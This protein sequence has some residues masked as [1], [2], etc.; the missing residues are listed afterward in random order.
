[1]RRFKG[2]TLTELMIALAVLGILIAVVTPAI[3]KARPNKN[4]M[5]TKKVYYTAENAVSALI[6]D[7]TVYPDV[8][9]LCVQDTSGN[10]PADC[11]WGFDYTN[12][13]KSE[14]ETYGNDTASDT[15]AKQKFGLLFKSKLNVKSNVGVDPLK[16]KTNDGIYWDLTGTTGA[17][18]KGKK[19]VGNFDQCKTTDSDSAGCGKILVNVEGKSSGGTVCSADSAD[20]NQFEIQV[21]ANG[22]MRINPENV[23]AINW[24]DIGSSIRN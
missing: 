19:K 2:F 13:V 22:K 5:M 17:W 7:E 14:G 24:I 1:M 4:K 16:F 20:C 6:N 9:Y 12:E 18:E 23:Q 21:L 8:R 11:A 10:V 15:K 3:M